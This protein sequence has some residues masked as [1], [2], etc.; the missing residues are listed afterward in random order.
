MDSLLCD[1][2]WLS[3]PATPDHHNQ[4]RYSHGENYAAASSFYTTKEDCEKAVSI[5][6][7]K[8]FT[9]MPE[10]GYVEHLRT[11]NLLFARLRA[12][13]WLIKSRERLSL[14]FETVF[15]AANYLDRFMSMNQCHGWKCWM[16]ELL[17]VACLS[18]ASKFTETRTPCLHDIQMEDLDHSF[19][20]ITI[21]RM[22]LVLLRALG[23]R[24][25][26]TT[27]YSY[28]ELLMM[29][30][31]F[32]KSYSYLQKDLVACRITELLLGA[33][34]DCSMVGFRPSITAISAL[35]CSLEEFVPS[36]SDAHL[37]HIKGLLNALDHKDDVVIK[38][39]GIMEA[40]LINPVYNLLACGKKHSYCCPSSPVTVLPTE[41]IGIY[42]CDVDLSFFNDSGSNN[43]QETSKKKRKWHE[44]S[45]KD[46]GFQKRIK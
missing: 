36:K 25:G 5:Y 43:K 30:I 20:P 40:Q 1:E 35:W 12:I 14:S 41:R 4:P 2:V 10:P 33:M 6:L 24:L 9:C 28:V 23:W 45:I 15:N 16:V 22:E 38:C 17:C 26:S 3:S 27:A 31:D 42:D 21:Q 29:E 19:Q 18:V 39:H 11:K 44:K 8:E 46:D 37:A 32:L 13:Q 7:E 34:Q